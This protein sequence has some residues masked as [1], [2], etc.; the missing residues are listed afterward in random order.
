MMRISSAVV[1]VALCFAT[2]VRARPQAATQ[3]SASS[4]SSIEIRAQEE[5]GR[6]NWGAALPL[7]TRV[8][9]QLRDS[10]QTDRLGAIEEQIRVCKKN[11]EKAGAVAAIVDKSAPETGE[12][13]KKHAAPNEGEV[14][15]LS[16]KEL[17]NFEYDAD[18]GGGIPG[19][20]KAMSGSVVKLHGFMI[21][22]D[23]ADSIT[24]FALVPSLFACC[25]GQPPQVQHTIV[26]H[27]PQGKGVSYFPDEI[28]VQGKLIV[29]EKKEDGFIV[30]IFEVDA[31]SVKPAAK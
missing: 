3:P 31:S 12:N 29:D 8:A 23:Q 26:V 17:G 14:R 24:Q 16:I 5:F 27:L 9:Q 19:D 11:L 6:A 10:N 22:M 28:T 30:S 20:V 13:R 4:A 18:V 15:E 7:L 25:F 21:P 2:P 1:L